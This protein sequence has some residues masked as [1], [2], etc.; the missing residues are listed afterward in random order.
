MKKDF[1]VLSSVSR[2]FERITQKFQALLMNFYPHVYVA[3][4]KVLTP[5]LLYFHLLKNIKKLLTVRVKLRQ[6]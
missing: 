4:E 5:N 6:C 1:S 2:V 3:I